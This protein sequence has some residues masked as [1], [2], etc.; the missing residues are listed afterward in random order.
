M[1]RFMFDLRPDSLDD[2]GLVATMRRYTNGYQERTGMTCRLNVSGEDRRLSPDLE[3]ALF[4]IIQEALN[5]AHKHSKAKTVEVNLHLTS[6]KA[7]ARVRDDGTGFDPR[8][9]QDAAGRRKLG[10]I[11]MSERAEALGGTLKVKSQPGHG[12][13]VLADFELG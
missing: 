1:R 6:A 9:Y 3:E 12:T 11:G 7:S 8:S 2:L 5:N 10:L 4:R 13:E